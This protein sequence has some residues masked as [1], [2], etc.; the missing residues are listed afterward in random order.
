[1][2]YILIVAV[3]HDCIH[4]SKEFLLPINYTLINVLKKKENGGEKHYAIFNHKKV[5]RK[6]KVKALITCVQGNKKIR[7]IIFVLW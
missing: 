3:V 4:L 2:F 7:H 6:N 5:W 1:M